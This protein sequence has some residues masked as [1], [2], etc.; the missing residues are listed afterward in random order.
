MVKIFGVEIHIDLG[1]IIK[2]YQKSRREK[3]RAE[4][5]KKLTRL[6]VIGNTF[7][8]SVKKDIAKKFKENYRFLEDSDETSKSS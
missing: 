4:L 3:E 2:E 5:A 1:N 6:E 7:N 8:D